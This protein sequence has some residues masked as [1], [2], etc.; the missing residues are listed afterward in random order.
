MRNS[1]NNM[2]LVVATAN[3][4]TERSRYCKSGDSFYIAMGTAGVCRTLLGIRIS[5]GLFADGV[6]LIKSVQHADT[7]QGL[8]FLA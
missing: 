6:K 1:W 3:I 5:G 8:N 4:R 2:G 7:G